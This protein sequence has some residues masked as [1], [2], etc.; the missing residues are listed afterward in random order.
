MWS[1]ENEEQRQ[2][3]GAEKQDR[4]QEQ[5]ETSSCVSAKKYDIAMKVLYL[6]PYIGKENV[7]LAPG[8]SHKIN[9]HELLAK[10]EVK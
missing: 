7:T 4:V 6:L 3:S 9:M 10:T 5:N 8:I 2:Q 1:P